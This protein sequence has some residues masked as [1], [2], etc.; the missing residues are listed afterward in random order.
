MTCTNGIFIFC[1]L[2]VNDNN[3]RSNNTNND[4]T[5]NNNDSNDNKQVKH[6]NFKVYGINVSSDDTTYIIVQHKS[7]N[8]CTAKE[9]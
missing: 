1:H 5:G 2:N 7:F 4:N 3:N 8:Y 9:R 6:K